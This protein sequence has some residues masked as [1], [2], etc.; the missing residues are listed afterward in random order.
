MRMDGAMFENER[1]FAF[2][3]H[4]PRFWVCISGV[5]ISIVSVGIFRNRHRPS[6]RNDG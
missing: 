6:T 3:E 4:D 5:K 1:G 2:R